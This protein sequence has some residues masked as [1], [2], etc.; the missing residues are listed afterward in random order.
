[1]QEG[2]TNVPGEKPE[3]KSGGPGGDLSK[4]AIEEREKQA[5]WRQTGPGVWGHSDEH[6]EEQPGG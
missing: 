1:M 4:E 3:E 2:R 5:G 6:S